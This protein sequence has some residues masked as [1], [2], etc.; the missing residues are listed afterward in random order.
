M[1]LSVPGESLFVRDAFLND[2]W[3]REPCLKKP[4]AVFC[5]RFRRMNLKEPVQPLLIIWIALVG[6]QTIDRP[7]R[8][9]RESRSMSG[10]VLP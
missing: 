10:G 5:A 3:I 1:V 4:S 8:Q 6:K 9:H 7:R 2:H